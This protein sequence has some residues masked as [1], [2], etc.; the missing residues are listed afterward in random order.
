MS[1]G[2]WKYIDEIGRTRTVISGHKI[3]E[4]TAEELIRPTGGYYKDTQ[5]YFQNGTSIK[6]KQY[7]SRRDAIEFHE[8]SIARA[9]IDIQKQK[10]IYANDLEGMKA[11]GYPYSDSYDEYIRFIKTNIEIMKFGKFTINVSKLFDLFIPSPLK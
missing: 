6:G 10:R 7:V 11:Q 4:L 9:K 1:P 5:I 8:K 2:E 3:Q